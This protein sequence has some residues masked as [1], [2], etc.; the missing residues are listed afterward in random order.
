MLCPISSIEFSKNKFPTKIHPF[1]HPF[2]PEISIQN[3]PW[4]HSHWIGLILGDNLHRKPMGF[5]HSNEDL[6]NLWGF[7]VKII[8]NQPTHRSS[9]RHLHEAPESLRATPT[10]PTKPRAALWPAAVTPSTSPRP[11]RIVWDDLGGHWR[12]VGIQVGLDMF[13]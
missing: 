7:P 4:S 12:V 9:H 13:R 11:L 1:F 2:H 6:W 5:Y 8:P 3:F 10:R